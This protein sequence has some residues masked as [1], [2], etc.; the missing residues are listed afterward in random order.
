M[1][2]YF[3]ET[4]Y[5][6]DGSPLRYSTE[7]AIFYPTREDAEQFIQELPASDI[8]F[9]EVVERDFPQK[10]VPVP[11]LG[12]TIKEAID[13]MLADHGELGQSAKDAVEIAIEEWIAS[14]IYELKLPVEKSVRLIHGICDEIGSQAWYRFCRMTEDKR[15]NHLG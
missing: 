15:F 12:E 2:L 1:K 4:K 9:Y 7:E 10:K 14:Y 6:G 3:V 11:T 13:Q 5:K 8:F